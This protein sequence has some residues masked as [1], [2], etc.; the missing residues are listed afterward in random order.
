[1]TRERANPLSS[2]DSRFVILRF[3]WTKKARFDYFC[4]PEFSI[5]LLQSNSKIC[6]SMSTSHQRGIQE[7]R[8]NTNRVT[9]L[10]L[11]VTKSLTSIDRPHISTCH[12]RISPPFS[13]FPGKLSCVAQVARLHPMQSFVGIQIYFCPGQTDIQ[14]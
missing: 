13:N 10:F 3:Q 2:H 11:A 7:D 14:T 5:D 9:A 1:M 8:S 12:W 6:V 4:N